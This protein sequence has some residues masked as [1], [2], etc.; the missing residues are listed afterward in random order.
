MEVT[1][2]NQELARWIDDAGLR[3]HCHLL[4]RR[5]DDIANVTAAL[6]IASLS[7]SYGEGFP[8]VVSEAMCCGVPCVVTDVGDAALIVGP[9]GIVV[10]PRNPGA[11]AAAWRT[12]LEMGCE[13]R[14]P[15]GIAA[16]QRIKERFDIAEI[17]GRY[18]HLFEELARGARA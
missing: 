12:M 10:P 18:E 8:N 17:T 7:S 11:L 14:R 6:D 15:M 5:D 9:T 1:W 13:G 3:T 2:E 16:R 4:G